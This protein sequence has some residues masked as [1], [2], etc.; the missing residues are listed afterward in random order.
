MEAKEIKAGDQVELW[1]NEKTLII[2]AVPYGNIKKVFKIVFEAISDMGKETGEAALLKVPRIM[3]ERVSAILP[4]LFKTGKYDFLTDEWIDDNLTIND[5]RKI[6]E[7]AIKVNGLEDFF[8][9][10]GNKPMVPPPTE[11][12]SLVKPTVS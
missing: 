9:K 3:E 8:A 2:E 7:T 6:I 12:V 10:M 1:V 4:L 5:I 11:P